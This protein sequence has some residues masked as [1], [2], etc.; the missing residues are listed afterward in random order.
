MRFG[1]TS[2]LTD[3]DYDTLCAPMLWGVIWDT[4]DRVYRWMRG[5]SFQAGRTRC[6]S[7]AHRTAIAIPP[8]VMQMLN[9]RREI[10]LLELAMLLG[11]ACIALA[12]AQA[13]RP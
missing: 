11:I 3:D 5:Q 2:T 12:W 8:N 13:V 10:M 6:T 7:V 4:Q 1:T 9:T